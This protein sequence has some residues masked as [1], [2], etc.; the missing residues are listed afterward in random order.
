VCICTHA[1][2]DTRTRAR[3]LEDITIKNY[4]VVAGNFNIYTNIT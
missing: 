4:K 3:A 2:T 1:S